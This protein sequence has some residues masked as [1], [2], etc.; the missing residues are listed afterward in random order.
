MSK[1]MKQRVY[2]KLISALWLA[3]CVFWMQFFTMDM[4]SKLTYQKK[5]VFDNFQQVV[6]RD[7]LPILIDKLGFAYNEILQVKLIINFFSKAY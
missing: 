4:L 5:H 6:Q 3:N 2:F 7:D 1:L